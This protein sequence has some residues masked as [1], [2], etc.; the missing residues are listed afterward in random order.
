[1]KKSRQQRI[2]AILALIMCTTTL[3]TGCGGPAAS[4]SPLDTGGLFWNV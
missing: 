2:V 3:F 4:E 1:M